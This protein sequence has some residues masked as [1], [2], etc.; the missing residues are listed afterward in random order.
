[1]RVKTWMTL[2]RVSNLPSVWTNVF[3]AALLAQASLLSSSDLQLLSLRPDVSVW[4]G[5]IVALSLM[6]L[7]GMF[8]NDAF[9]ADWDRQHK[10]TRPIANGEVSVRSVWTNGL[11]ML[12]LGAALIGFLYQSQA[13]AD[14]GSYWGWLAAVLLALTITLYNA[15]HKSF[16]HSAWF[17]GAC[18]LGVYLIAALLLAELTQVLLLAAVSLLLYIAGITY[19]ACSEHENHL[20]SRWPLLLL[21]SPLAVGIYL[22]YQHLYFW[23]FAVGFCLWVI[24]RIR[25]L[26]TAT[27]NVR[28]CIGGLLAAIP[29]F[30]GLILASVNLVLPSVAC[31][32][33]FFTLPRLQRWVSAT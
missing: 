23:L 2:G 15:V 16:S 28:G 21:F 1:M 25:L 14:T 3:A 27:P 11:I 4:L 26:N 7:G 29:L 24:S 6:Y 13:S 19:V 20:L 31:L 8:L 17:M 22:G 18:R 33:I 32:I 30:D 10:N 12:A 5:C 9:D